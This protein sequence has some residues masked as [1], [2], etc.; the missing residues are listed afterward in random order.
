ML[1]LVTVL[2]AVLVAAMP[3][4]AAPSLNCA[5]ATALSE[6]A[7]CETWQLHWSD[8]QLSRLYTLARKDAAEAQRL[9][10]IASQRRFVACASATAPI[11][12]RKQS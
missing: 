1:R 8:R 10:L 9:G 4:T 7:I 12:A 5:K 6:K 3:A 11:Q 2:T